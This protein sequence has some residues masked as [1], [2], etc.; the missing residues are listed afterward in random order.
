MAASVVAPPI[1][2]VENVSRPSS[3]ARVMAASPKTVSTGISATN[4]DACCGVEEP[5]PM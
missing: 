2:P 5:S 1:R 3:T 4:T